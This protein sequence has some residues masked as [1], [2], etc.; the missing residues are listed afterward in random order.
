MKTTTTGTRERI[1]RSTSR[2]LQ[3]QGYEGTGIK[4]ISREAEATLGSV[5]HFF[6]G[7]KQELAAEAIRHSDRE[8]AELLRAG[9]AA[10]DDPAEAMT[11]CTGL[12]ATG[13][14]ESDWQ[15]GCPITSTALE[16]IGRAPVI[17]QAVAEAFT[18]WRAVVAEKLLAAGLGADDAR[19]LAATVVSTLEGAEL[20][21]QVAR[22]EEPLHLAGKH[23]ARL[24]RSYC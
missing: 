2:L 14:R 6:P 23:L 19:E 7:G 9:L 1:V 5:Y 12:L 21:A 10:A 16:T 17:E 18:H 4:Q 13:L 8:F 20:T 22:S 3:R 11:A 24:V 15:D